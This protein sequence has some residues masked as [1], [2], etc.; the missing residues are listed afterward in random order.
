MILVAVWDPYL[1]EKKASNEVASALEGIRTRL[2][3]HQKADEIQCQG[4]VKMLI[5]ILSS[6]HQGCLAATV[7]DIWIGIEFCDQQ[8]CYFGSTSPRGM[9]AST[10]PETTETPGPGCPSVVWGES[11]PAIP[12]SVQESLEHPADQPLIKALDTKWFGIVSIRLRGCDT[13][14]I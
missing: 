13:A 1:F 5:A 3:E 12:R 11:G 7:N 9:H 4:F 10:T 14:S 2:M 8:A 6:P